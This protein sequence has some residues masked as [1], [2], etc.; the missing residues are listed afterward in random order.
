MLELDT[1]LK[2]NLNINFLRGN[3]ER[4]VILDL[5]LNSSLDQNS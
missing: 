3:L 2:L 5:D 1:V 4:N